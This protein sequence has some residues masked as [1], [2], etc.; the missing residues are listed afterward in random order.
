MTSR[1]F[2]S[3]ALLIFSMP[4]LLGVV[5]LSQDAEQIRYLDGTFEIWAT[6]DDSTR[7]IGKILVAT[8][9]QLLAQEGDWVEVSISGWTQ[10]GAERVIYAAPGM[11]VLRATVAK[12]T[13]DRLTFSSVQEDPDTELTWTRTELRGWLRNPALQPT[14]RDVWQRAEPLFAER[15]TACH[16]RRIPHHYTANQWS[17]HLKVM[18]PRTGLPKEDQFLIRAY[19]QYHAKDSDRLSAP[20]Y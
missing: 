17:S 18:G 14:L 3:V 15:C 2:L 16:Q 12:S 11:R 7:P 1:T 8:P 19:L 6:P 9:V 20:N 13:E 4:W 10:T 5:A